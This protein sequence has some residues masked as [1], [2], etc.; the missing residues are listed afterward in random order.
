MII[1]NSRRVILIKKMNE[2]QI[3]H[4]EVIQSIGMSMGE[5]RDCLFDMREIAQG[6]PHTLEIVIALLVDQILQ[7]VSFPLGVDNIINFI[8][9]VSI[10]CDV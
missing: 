8:F 3:D 7:L 5:V 2:I 6:F 4:I 10:L 1:I 9:L